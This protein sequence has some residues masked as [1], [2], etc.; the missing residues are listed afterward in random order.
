MRLLKIWFQHGNLPEIQGL[1][2]EGVER[3]DLKVWIEVI[4]QLLAR[5]DIQDDIIRR[6]LVELLEKISL[7]FPQAILYSLSVQENSTSNQRKNAARA[8]ME[9]LKTTQKTLIEQAHTI[10]TE[11]NRSAIVL[12]E[13]WHEAIQEASRIY[14]GK[15]DGKAMYNY[16]QQYHKI[17]ENEPETM[18]EVAFYQGYASDLQEAYSWMKL[19]MRTERMTDINQAWDIYYSIFR[20]ISTKIKEITFY[21]LRN[22]APKLLASEDMEIAVPGT[23]RSNKPIVKIAKF[24]SVL[25]VLPSK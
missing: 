19:Y 25:P 12:A 20:R 24:A 13:M 10:S 8:L 9:K 18:N 7:K 11:L 21:E 14:F 3:I 5:I 16:L 17:M 15:Q 2:K 1:L 22:V 6:T 23:F 4:P